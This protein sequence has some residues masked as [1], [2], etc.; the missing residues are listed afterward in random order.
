[1]PSVNNR[2]FY[3]VLGV[4]PGASEAD[5]KKAYRK[6]AMK[7]HPDR[8][9]SPEAN[10]KFQAISRAYDVLSDP[11]KRKVY[12]MY[13]EEGLNGGAPTGGPRTSAGPGGATYTFDAADA[14]R[15]FRQFFG[16]MGGGG[17]GMGGG[18]GGPGFQ[19][20]SFGGQPRAKQAR[21]NPFGSS[22]M[23]FGGGNSGMDTSD[24]SEDDFASLFGGARGPGG[25][26]SR[27]QCPRTAPPQ[28]PEVVQRKVPVSLEDL[29]TGFT[30]RMRVQRRIQDSQTGAITT[31]SNILTVEGRP[32]VKAG[33]KYTFAGA[34]DELNARPRQDIQF[35]LE[36]KPHPTFKRDGDDVVTTVKVPLVDAL[37]GCT[38]QVPKLG[39][40][41]VPLTLDR[42]TP[43]TVKI[44]AGEGMPKRHGGAGNLKVRFDVQFPAQPLTPD[45]KQGV[46]NFLPRA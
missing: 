8:N 33:T 45:Q 34:G 15:I 5:L 41:S 31:T 20:F 30:K 36:E 11:E 17:M 1:M 7:W 38:V 3:D 4:A 16:G 27:G 32:G 25:G 42:I 9:K 35:V 44:V 37:C 40:G 14:D 39:G 19:S 18:M 22:G 43:Q 29:K 2:K 6:L 13:G 26:C 10:E 24:D 23:F 46:R 12:D 28:Q 21:R